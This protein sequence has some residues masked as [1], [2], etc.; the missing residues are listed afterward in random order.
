VIQRIFIDNYKCFTNFECRLDAMQL[1]LGDNGSGKTSVFD[2]LGTLRDMV[3]L[4]VPA[5]DAFPYE[6][7][8]AWDTRSVQAFELGL[9]G[10]DGHYLYRLVIEHDRPKQRNR[11]QSEELRFDQALLYQFDGRE[12]HLF[13]DDVSAP[14]GPVF[15][16]DWSRSAIAT[17]PER[18]ENQKLSWFR[19]R[20]ERVLIFSPDP[21]RMTALSEKELPNPDRRLRDLAS[22]M[23][24]LW[25]QQA[26][27]GHTM[28]TSLKEVIDGLADLRF[29]RLS[30]TISQLDFEFRFG[31]DRNPTPARPFHLAFDKLS[32][33]QRMLVALYTILLAPVDKDTTVCL[34]EPDN[35]V[36]L[37]ELQ[38]WLAALRDRIEER[39]GQ[40]LLISHH[41]EFI[42]YLAAK[43][44]LIFS[45][46]E[47]GPAR[48]KAFEWT[49]EE[50]FL[51]AEI[52]ARG[53]E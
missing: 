38:P 30:E 45:R 41:P 3:T 4:G 7:L 22:W 53:W 5:I 2:V 48:A 36:S 6:T 52:I 46:D 19:R 13:R 16:F 21:V 49:G 37:R 34:D 50:A 24:H 43:H 14:P 33:G 26:D 35:F 20:M 32:D 29:K 25:Q 44:G 17:I 9:E 10:N 40:C 42:N 31:D 1:L 23:R 12:A 18:S 15:P 8:T 27:F 28:L 47:S 51:P 39:G 11:I